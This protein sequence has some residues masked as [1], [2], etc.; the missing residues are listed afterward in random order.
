MA[1]SGAIDFGPRGLWWDDGPTVLVAHGTS[2]LYEDAVRR[3]GLV[4]LASSRE[5]LKERF[6]GIL[7]LMVPDRSLWT[8]GLLEMVDCHA[9]RRMVQGADTLFFRFDPSQVQGYAEQASLNGGEFANDIAEWV[10]IEL[11][12]QPP[13]LHEGASPMVV[14]AEVDKASVEHPRDLARIREAMIRDWVADGR[15]VPFAQHAAEHLYRA[16]VRVRGA[17]PA[18]RI[19]EI[20]VLA[21]GSVPSSRL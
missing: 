9:A 14:I 4:P 15:T 1:A 16:E 10:R 20:R 17:V 11:G 12:V 5:G 3:D 18:D 13:R 6:L 19:R 2:S 21:P 7:G 8:P